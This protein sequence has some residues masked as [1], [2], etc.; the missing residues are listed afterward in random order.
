MARKKK[1]EKVVEEVIESTDQPEVQAEEVPEVEVPVEQPVEEEVV[2]VVE[3]EEGYVTVNQFHRS[4]YA[5]LKGKI[6]ADLVSSYKLETKLGLVIMP[7]DQV[8]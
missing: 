1:V 2:E 3:A 4:A 7:K 5:G 6:V 8:S